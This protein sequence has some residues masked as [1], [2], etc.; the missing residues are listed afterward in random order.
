M[1]DYDYYNDEDDLMNDDEFWDDYYS[2]DDPDVD[3]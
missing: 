3:F 1:S 2:A